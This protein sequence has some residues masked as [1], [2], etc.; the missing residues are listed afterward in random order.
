MKHSPQG[1]TEVFERAYL[2]R[3]FVCAI[4]R[5]GVQ[6][7]TPINICIPEEY[8]AFEKDKLLLTGNP[9][10]QTVNRGTNFLL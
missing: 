5:N 8:T 3:E 1:K 2:S 7:V 9:L 10:K 4:D 6:V